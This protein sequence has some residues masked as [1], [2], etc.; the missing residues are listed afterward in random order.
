MYKLM[1]IPSQVILYKLFPV[2]SRKQ[3]FSYKLYLSIILL[4]TGVYYATASEASINQ[5]GMAIGIFT[6]VICIPIDTVYNGEIARVNH[7]NSLEMNYKTGWIRALLSGGVALMYE[8]TAV[9][10]S[11]WN[12]ASNHYLLSF[13]CW[14]FLSCIFAIGEL[15]IENWKVVDLSVLI[16]TFT[17]IVVIIVVIHFYIFQKWNSN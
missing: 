1:V 11:L 14:L 2:S 3:I 4:L 5:L 13:S 10:D 6:S 15:K 9:V 8:R 17:I 12:M 16:T 7:W